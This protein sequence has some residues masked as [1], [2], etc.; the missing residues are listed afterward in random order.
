MRSSI[1]LYDS[2]AADY[3]AHFT[4]AHRRAYDDLAWEA[5]VAR[6]PAP[7]AGPVVDVGCGAGRWAERILD[8]GHEVV[9]V[10]QAPGMAAAA[11]GR[12][13]GPSVS[14]VE[15]PMETAELPPGEASAVIA[16]GSL[17]YA[18]DPTAA[19]TRAVGW[20]RPGAPVL[21]LVDSLVALV[22]ELER[23]GRGDEAA[24][25]LATHQGEWHQGAEIADLHLFDRAALAA[26]MAAAGVVDV[27]VRGLLVGWSV[28]GRNEMVDR[29]TRDWDATLDHER[30]LAARPELADL[31]KQLL[32]VGR[33][34]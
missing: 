14:V 17:Q 6:L 12:G 16:M 15:A 28:W 11:R 22:I 7:G 13:L 24:E 30:G 20:A 33:R 9:G 23:A 3:D 21:V 18:P 5:T 2:L 25:R 29:L 10:E 32:A 4:V 27:E 19:L 34:A 1:P 31:G 26:T 8:L